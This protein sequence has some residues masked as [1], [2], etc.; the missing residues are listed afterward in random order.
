MTNTTT[1]RKTAVTVAVL[2]AFGLGGAAIAGAADKGAPPQRQTLTTDVAAK[3]KAAAIEKVPGAT[4]LR[5]EA[6]GPYGT[7]YHAHVRTS[8]GTRKVVL[9][10]ASF[11]ATE[12][13]ADRGRGR[14]DG[15]GRHGET[16]LTGETK[17]KVEA[18]VLAEYPGAT[19]VR[20]ET[21]RDSRAAYESHITT[22][23]GKEL[24]VLVSR[25]FE[26]V[27]ARERPARP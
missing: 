3:V 1:L 24:E 14:P 2:G 9:V 17:Q 15:P 21:N 27:D 26:V 16:A 8:D 22:G 19:V 20:T 11:E 12:V 25:D 4:V 5:T 10:N 6:G 13:Q 7:A 18:A 23:D